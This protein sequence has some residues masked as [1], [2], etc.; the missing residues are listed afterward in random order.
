[1]LNSSLVMYDRQTRS[2]WSPI[3]AEAIVGTLAGTT[4]R[5]IPTIMMSWFEFSSAH[6][7]GIVLS[8]TTGY[9]R[10]YGRNPY[11]GYDNITSQPFLYEG[12]FDNRLAPMTEVLLLQGATRSVAI[13]VD[14]LRSTRT[15]QLTIGSD[16]AVF[17]YS[18]GTASALDTRQISDGKDVGTIG[19][20]SADET[21]GPL[22]PLDGPNDR[23]LFVSQDLTQWTVAGHA[24]A[25]AR[26]GERLTAFEHLRTFW[27]L[28]AAFNPDVQVVLPNKSVPTS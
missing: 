17:L 4:L 1:L 5:V 12:P 23:Q 28:A 8:Q 13:P 24:T 9:D 10:D 16:T 20:Y 2:L 25:G 21:L 22:T 26:S 3:R 6:P 7:D 27:F 15:T 18:P 19:V 11:P 14:Q